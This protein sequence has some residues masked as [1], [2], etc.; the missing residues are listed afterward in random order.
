MSL[1][2]ADVIDP[3]A[4]RDSSAP[5][6]LSYNAAL[7]VPRASNP[8]QCSSSPRAAPSWPGSSQVG[9]IADNRDPQVD[10]PR[11]CGPSSTSSFNDVVVQSGCRGTTSSFIHSG[12]LIVGC[13]AKLRTAFVNGGRKLTPFR[14]LKIDPLVFILR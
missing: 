9:F 3:P 7:S 8:S 5:A 11:T 1:S 4:S 6:D 2:L 12:N 14:R 10:G 13:S